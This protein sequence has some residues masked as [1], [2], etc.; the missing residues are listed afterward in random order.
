MSG[1]VIWWQGLGPTGRK[2]AHP[3]FDSP[4]FIQTDLLLEAFERPPRMPAGPRVDKPQAP[5]LL[6]WVL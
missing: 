1:S 3:L 6:T 4:H 2:R 5:V